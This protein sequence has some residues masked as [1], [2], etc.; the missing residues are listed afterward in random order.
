[1]KTKRT[2]LAAGRPLTKRERA[3]R[4][5]E[6]LCRSNEK[7]APGSTV[8]SNVSAPEP[9]VKNNRRIYLAVR[10]DARKFADHCGLSPRACAGIRKASSSSRISE[11][12]VCVDY[13]D[14]FDRAHILAAFT[15]A[16]VVNGV[17]VSSC[18]AE[19]FFD[20]HRNCRGM[21]IYISGPAATKAK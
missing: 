3:E 16:G 20:H 11:T 2:R 15:Y 14:I 21:L 9:A 12:T 18:A 6:G 19:D 13:I 5:A 10:A 7:E 4:E 1:M 8:T 17:D